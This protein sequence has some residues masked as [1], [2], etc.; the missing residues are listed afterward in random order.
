MN[1]PH[2]LIMRNKIFKIIPLVFLVILIFG[3]IF[4]L[5]TLGDK[6]A[7]K[8][9]DDAAGGTSLCATFLSVGEA[10][11]TLVSC[12]GKFLLVDGGRETMGDEIVAA[13][14]RSGATKLDYIICTHPHTDHVGAMAQVIDEIPA[15]KLYCPKRLDEHEI[16]DKMLGM[17]KEKGVEII[18]PERGD[19]FDVGEATVVFLSADT[20]FEDE[21]DNGLIFMMY[22]G[23]N[24]FLFMADSGFCAE[25]ELMKSGISLDCDILKVGHHGSATATSEDFL[26]ACG[27]QY[28]VISSG[29]LNKSLPS[30]KTIDRLEK[31]GVQILRTDE[32]GDVV[33]VSDG[34]W[35]GVR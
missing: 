18:N 23:E 26:S 17:A 32:M 19:S 12:D 11:C 24:G 9:G 30:D 4:A 27:P 13:I 3:A 2:F 35:V 14:K 8:I 6:K 16:F 15:E 1:G 33:V 28:A 7:P 5:N 20:V 21:N 22:H 25:E 34:K 31:S 10:D 29:K